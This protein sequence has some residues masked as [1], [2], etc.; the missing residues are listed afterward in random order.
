MSRPELERVI[1]EAISK[2]DF[3]QLLMDSPYDALASYDLD[4]REV[5]ALIAAS[6]PD[7]LALGVD[8][9]LVRKYVNIFHISRGGGG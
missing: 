2:E 6:E 8:P 3:L 7:L 5:G 4:P 9:Q 1:V